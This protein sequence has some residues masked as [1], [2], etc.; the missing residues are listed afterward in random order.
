MPLN[1]YT[2]LELAIAIAA[3]FPKPAPPPVII[4]TLFSNFFIIK[5]LLLCLSMTHN[6]YGFVQDGHSYSVA[7]L[8]GQR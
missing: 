2:P 3:P 1:R 6:G 5:C 8:A 4:A 7:G